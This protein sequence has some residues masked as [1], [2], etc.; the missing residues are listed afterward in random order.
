MARTAQL[1]NS[2]ASPEDALTAVM[3]LA[4]ETV[5]AERGFIMLIDPVSGTLAHRI[6]RNF[7]GDRGRDALGVSRTLV[8]HVYDANE[9][10]FNLD[11]SRDDRFGGAESVR[12]FGL[13][14]I[15]C[16]PLAVRGRRV[17][18]IYLDNRVKAG[19]FEAEDVDFVVAF[20]HQAAIALDAAMVADLRR[21]HADALHREQ[22]AAVGQLAAGMAH[23]IN[24]PLGT[25]LANAQLLAL[26]VQGPEERESV[27]A[28]VAGA[29]QARDVVER[30]LTWYRAGTDEEVSRFD[31]LEAVRDVLRLSRVAA[32]VEGV[33]RPVEA[34]RAAVA[35]ILTALL[36]N[37]AKV[38]GDVRVRVLAEGI[39][40]IDGGP[41]IPDE[42]LPHIFDPFF[43]TRPPG[44]GQG[45]G[46]FVAR[47]LAEKMGA[48]LTVTQPPTCFALRL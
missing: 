27:A 9:P 22:R 40:V 19:A 7:E 39:Q 34:N 3:D 46:L 17:G 11:V 2:T 4:M 20:S 25:I 10:Y 5:G 32:S 26:D 16:A 15:I 1:I 45:L 47:A 12:A 24:N 18:A 44:Q 23:E 31:L 43:T 6:A 30:L 14:A 36:D 28:I 21:Q 42:A 37:A 35:Q 8:Q 33:S 13:R 48:A 38:S 41:G 29:R